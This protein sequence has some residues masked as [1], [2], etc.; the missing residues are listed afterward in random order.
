MKISN[1][2]TKVSALALCVCTSVLLLSGCLCSENPLAPRSAQSV[3]NR[4]AGVW[5]GKVD[6]DDEYLH[7]FDL[8]DGMSLKLIRVRHIRGGGENHEEMEM[9]PTITSHS[10]YL[11]LNIACAQKDDPGHRAWYFAKY[12]ISPNQEFSV[13]ML[14]Y[15]VFK[16]AIQEKKLVGEI[17]GSG[18][19]EEAHIKDSSEHMLAFAESC[20]ADTYKLYGKFRR[21]VDAPEKP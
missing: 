17:T 13:W 4:L 2:L 11:N 1:C 8:K 19:N 5:H 14:G 16:K 10:H 21:V 3:D 20:P 18:L 9:Y 6:N 15:D 7:I 12:E